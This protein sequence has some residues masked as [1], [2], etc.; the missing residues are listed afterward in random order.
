MDFVFHPRPFLLSAR[1][2]CLFSSCFSFVSFPAPPFEREL[3]LAL[4]VIQAAIPFSFGGWGISFAA[5]RPPLYLHGP[6]PV[7]RFGR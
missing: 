4:S 2:E 6:D 7:R 5:T 3:V 1:V